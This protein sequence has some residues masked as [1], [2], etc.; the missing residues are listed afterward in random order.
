MHSFRTF[1]SMHTH[2][3]D[4]EEVLSDFFMYSYSHILFWV[5]SPACSLLPNWNA[6]LKHFNLA[7]R[8]CSFCDCFDPGP[9]LVFITLV[10]QHFRFV[11]GGPI[12]LFQCSVPRLRN[13]RYHRSTE[14]LKGF[15]CA[16][17]SLYQSLFLSL[18]LSLSHLYV[19]KFRFFY[20]ISV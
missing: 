1:Q 8:G 15:V 19:L 6:F 9:S 7:I 13:P 10:G 18:S 2:L 14:F 4:S 5:L 20:L 11:L 17:F 12:T 16:H 3:P